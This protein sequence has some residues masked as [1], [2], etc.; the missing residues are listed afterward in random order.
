MADEG[1][2]GWWRRSVDRRL[3]HLEGQN[4]A[5]LAT[6]LQYVEDE[7]HEVK[8]TLTWVWRTLVGLSVTIIGGALVYAVSNGLVGGH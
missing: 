3:E 6:R 4:V 8:Q 5:V 2:N 7:L 1:V